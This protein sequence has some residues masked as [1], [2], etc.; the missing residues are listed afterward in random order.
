MLTR[1]A[2]V[3]RLSSLGDVLLT[4]PVFENL[5]RAWPEARLTLL[6]KKAFAPALAGHPAVDELLIFEDLGFWGVL[7]EIRRRRFDALIDL[8]DTPRSRL[9]TALSKAGRVVRYRKRAWARRRLVWFKRPSAELAGKTVDRYLE[10]LA[11][12]GVEVRDRVPRLPSPP[13]ALPAPATTVAPGPWIVVAPGALHATKRW[14]SDRFAAAADRLAEEFRAAGGPPPTVVVVG[15]ASDGPAAEEVLETLQ[16]PALNLT[17]RTSLRE[18]MALLSRAAVLLC[19]DSGAMHLGAALGVPTVAVFG[20]TV[21]AFGFFP[22][23]EKTAVVQ[24]G[25]LNCRPCALHGGRRCPQKHFRCMTDVTVDRVVGEA[26]R[27][28]RGAS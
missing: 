14:P 17:G 12:L 15:S 21:E 13:D 20:P 22:S 8:H 11:D 1:S 27:L 5:R 24:N 16:G 25:G 2:L 19:N 7:R 9:W 26:R 28:L 4:I 3:V 6:V 10:T 23:G 18:L